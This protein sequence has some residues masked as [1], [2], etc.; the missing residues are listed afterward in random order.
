MA[1]DISDRF[2]L[3]PDSAFFTKILEADASLSAADAAAMSD[4]FLETT[5]PFPPELLCKGAARGLGAVLS[6]AAPLE[7][8]LKI[9]GFAERQTLASYVLPAC[10]LFACAPLKEGFTICKAQGSFCA[11]LMQDRRLKA[12]CSRPAAS[13]ADQDDARAIASLC[14]YAGIKDGHYAFYELSKISR[15][16]PLNCKFT[17]KSPANGSEISW[18]IKTSVLRGFM[19]VRSSDTLRA[20]AKAKTYAM[21]S[22][23]AAY[24]A[25][26][27]FFGLAAWQIGIYAQRAFANADLR[28]LEELAPQARRVELMSEQLSFLKT[29]S[30]KTL[31]NAY[32]LGVVNKYR[33][34][35][36]EF[37]QTSA[38][39]PLEMQIKGKADSID[40]VNKFV[41]VLKA[42]P[43]ISGAEASIPSSKSGNAQFV[44]TVTFKK[45]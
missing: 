2:L 28:R 30:Q 25:A 29:F 10:A 4:T 18:S 11:I 41:E 43:A 40:S 34:A 44:L 37:A 17:L 33:P 16:N 6:Y 21:F 23:I 9:E 20:V 38:K 24:A 7:R 35:A 39:S 5:S 32:M 19:D 42:D 13:D 8:L 36:L 27:A 45:Q 22:A 15:S 26:G 1:K 12:V 31:F 14:E 3:L